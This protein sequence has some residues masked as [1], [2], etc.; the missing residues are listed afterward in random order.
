MTPPQLSLSARIDT[1]TYAM[2]RI[3]V[4]SHYAYLF[5]INRSAGNVDYLVT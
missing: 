4:R 1:L 5:V 3:T 2:T